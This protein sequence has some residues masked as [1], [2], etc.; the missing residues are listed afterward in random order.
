[1]NGFRAVIFMAI[2]MLSSCRNPQLNSETEAFGNPEALKPIIPAEISC[3]EDP[4]IDRW[5]Y[6]VR[7]TATGSCEMVAVKGQLAPVEAEVCSAQ[8]FL[9]NNGVRY[10]IA[11]KGNAD[12]PKGFMNVWFI[13]GEGE[14]P[15]LFT[16]DTPVILKCGF[17]SG[18]G[19][20]NPKN[21]NAGNSTSR[22]PTS[23]PA[24][25]SARYK[26][27]GYE[28]TVTYSSKEDCS[29]AGCLNICIKAN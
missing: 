12:S 24:G 27:L 10:Q 8:T 23:P 26:C 3:I 13:N 18:G 5:N 9:E 15:A 16:N 21:K 28:G 19:L 11:L 25:S 29:K 1:M 17:L 7:V 14:G 6:T 4:N 20:A 22:P 2:A